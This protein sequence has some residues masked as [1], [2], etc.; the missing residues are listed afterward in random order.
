MNNAKKGAGFLV[1]KILQDN[2][3]RFLGLLAPIEKRIE[4]RGIYDLPKGGVKEG[5]SAL[6]CAK[7]E[8]EEESGII[9][10]DSDIIGPGVLSNGITIFPAITDQNPHILKNP[11]TGI[12]EHEAAHWIKRY[13]ME[14]LCLDYLKPVIELCMISFRDTLNKS[15]HK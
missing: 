5:E 15:D 2:S 7:R 9:I 14:D 4:K 1:G 11:E 10:K 12:L 3:V 8:C 13:E 6:D